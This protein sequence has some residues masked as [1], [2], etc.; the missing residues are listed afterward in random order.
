ML[1]LAG[2][3]SRWSN[4]RHKKA[5]DPVALKHFHHHD[6]PHQMHTIAVLVAV[7]PPDFR[8]S[9]LSE[10]VPYPTHTAQ[11]STLIW[12]TLKAASTD[13]SSNPVTSHSGC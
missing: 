11:T 7:A 9:G 6:G 1:G 3:Y 10:P 5:V 2:A 12:P 8:F 13:G 4:I